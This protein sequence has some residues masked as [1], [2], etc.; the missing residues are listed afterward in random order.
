MTGALPPPVEHR[1]AVCSLRANSRVS[2][3]HYDTEV[4]YTIGRRLFKEN[5]IIRELNVTEM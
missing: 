5:Y 4:Y 3:S 2:F 1:T